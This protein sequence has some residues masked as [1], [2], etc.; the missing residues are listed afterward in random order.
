MPNL[1]LL[2]DANEFKFGSLFLCVECF[3]LISTIYHYQ[4]IYKNN[5][6]LLEET[7]TK[8]DKEIPALLEKSFEG[9][10]EN[11]KGLIL[12]KRVKPLLEMIKS[13]LLTYEKTANKKFKVFFIL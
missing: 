2:I 11:I 5:I 13:G 10:D 9:K 3:T 1:I 8:L 7:L 4:L 12:A 6:S